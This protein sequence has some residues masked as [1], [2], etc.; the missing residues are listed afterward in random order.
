[1][2]RI[3]LLPWREER[4]KERQKQ[5]VFMLAGAVALGALVSLWGYTTMD[6]VIAAQEARNDFLKQ[7]IAEIDKQ[8]AQIKDLKQT[9]SRLLARM[10]IIEQLQKSRP[11]V[12]HL[13]AE[14]V[15][16][17]PDGVYLTAFKQSGDKLEMHGVAESSAR[18]AAY[19]RNIDASPW[20][21]DP[22]V[23]IIE[24]KDKENQRVRRSEFIVRATQASP[25][26]E[27]SDDDKV[28]STDRGKRK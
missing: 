2:P 10:R 24:S 23:D 25:D 18:V 4:R 7:Q 12:V 5:F 26:V 6:R 15:K 11:Q 20:M 22:S 13:F 14:L 21:N 28:G 3:N 19:M 17:L 8:I 9:K 27:K 1:M 16:T